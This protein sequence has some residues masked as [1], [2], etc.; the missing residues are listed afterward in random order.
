V[1]LTSYRDKHTD[2]FGHAY[3][4]ASPEVSSDLIQMFRY[5]EKLAEPGRQLVESGLVSASIFLEQGDPGF[6]I[7]WR[8]RLNLCHH[9]AESYSGA[10]LLTFD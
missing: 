3:C 2:A 1:Y 10:S 7:S 8:R 5:G 4:A 9:L 6:S